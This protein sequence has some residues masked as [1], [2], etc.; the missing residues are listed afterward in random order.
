MRELGPETQLALQRLAEAKQGRIG[1]EMVH[2]AARAD[3]GER[4]RDAFRTLAAASPQVRTQGIG[5]F[6]AD[7]A[8]ASDAA[9]TATGQ[10][11]PHAGSG[12]MGAPAPGG[13]RPSPRPGRRTPAS[14]ERRVHEGVVNVAFKHLEAKLRF[15]E[16]TIGQWAAVVAG[17]LFGLVFAQYLSPVG[18]RVGHGARDLPGGDPGQRRVLC[19]P[20]RVRPRR[21]AGRRACG[22]G[23]SPRA[24]CR[25]RAARRRATGSRRTAP[26]ATGA[27]TGRDELDL[28]ALWD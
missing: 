23:A 11:A 24:I 10:P 6:A 9:R 14:R 18:G 16:L 28:E 13:R 19:Q 27:L 17:V 7:Q 22:A 2:Q 8:G 4:E 1:G 12:P 20:E 3:L 26:A 25:A 21:P 5:D 15:G